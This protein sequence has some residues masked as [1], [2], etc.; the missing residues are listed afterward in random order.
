MQTRR[1]VSTYKSRNRRKRDHVEG[2][3]HVLTSPLSEID[4]DE[5]T[6]SEMNRRMGKRSRLLAASSV[7]DLSIIADASMDL[8]PTK[9]SKRPRA[10]DDAPITSGPLSTVFNAEL[11]AN[12]FQTPLTSA[13][14]LGKRTS[15]GYSHHRS[16]SSLSP[17]PLAKP[18]FDSVAKENVIG[19]QHQTYLASPFNSQPNSRNASPR[20]SQSKSK[21]TKRPRAKSRTLSAHLPENREITAPTTDAAPSP[22][23]KKAKTLHHGRNP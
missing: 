6:L 11:H 22:D 5:T 3:N 16:A 20:K 1:T 14:Q 15:S 2:P 18:I 4:K 23:R 21:P 10:G 8:A 7:P 12:S 9:K 19:S 17:V 13:L